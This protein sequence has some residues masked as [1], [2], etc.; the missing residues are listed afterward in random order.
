MK[1]I[2]KQGGGGYH[3]GQAH[4][5][6]PTSAAQARSRWSGFGHKAVVEQCLLDE[7][8]QL[9]CYSE[10]RADQIGLGYHIEHVQPKSKYPQLTF[11]YS[12]LAASALNS[13]AD[14]AN[15]KSQASEVFGGHAKGSDYDPILFVSCHQPDCARFFAYLSDGRVVPRDGLAA[16]DVARA[17][18]TIKLLN[19]N[20]PY[21]RSLRERWWDE[22]QDLFDEHQVK[23]WSLDHLVALDLVPAGASLS[24]FFSL[25]RQFF[26]PVAEGVLGRQAPQLL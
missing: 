3:L 14:L 2:S 26:G 19:L 23:G 11:D 25:T 18:Y 8:F 22:L 4:L 6:P 10:I 24:A 13:E 9:C 17:D 5:N 20:S 16:N 12:N 21:L 7:Q 1:P 15:L